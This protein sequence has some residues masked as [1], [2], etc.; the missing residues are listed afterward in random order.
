MPN[1]YSEHHALDLTARADMLESVG[2][3][4]EGRFLL[5][6]RFAATNLDNLDVESC[7]WLACLLERRVAELTYNE[8]DNDA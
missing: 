3:Y 1:G 2:G 4:G 8:E 7:R 6:L 5:E